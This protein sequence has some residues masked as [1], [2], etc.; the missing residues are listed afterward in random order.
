MHL[1]A[2]HGDAISV[3]YA[4]TAAL[5]GDVTRSGQRQLGGLLRDGVNSA[6]RYYL[7]HMRDAQTQTAIDALLDV[8][9]TPTLVHYRQSPE[10]QVYLWKFVDSVHKLCTAAQDEKTPSFIASWPLFDANDDV[11]VVLL[12]R[13]VL[14][15]AEEPSNDAIESI[16]LHALSR[17][18]VGVGRSHAQ[19]LYVRVTLNDGRWYQ[20]R[21]AGTRLFNNRPMALK[22]VDEQNEYTRAIAEQIVVTCSLAGVANLQIKEVP[23]LALPPTPSEHIAHAVA[24]VL[25]L[26][27]GA[28]QVEEVKEHSMTLSKSCTD[29]NRDVNVNVLTTVPSPATFIIEPVEEQSVVDEHSSSPSPAKQGN[30]NVLLKGHKYTINTAGEGNAKLSRIASK[31]KDLIGL[32]K[33]IASSSFSKLSKHIQS[34]AQKVQRD[35]TTPKLPQPPPAPTYQEKHL[36]KIRSSKS[37]IMLL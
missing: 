8:Q 2:D 7:C 21:S 4:G 25:F 34:T 20:W 22:S 31:G 9:A 33:G 10:D 14:I 26:T 35:L 12:T 15:V 16:D 13:E 29:L 11:V 37:Q 18:E 32:S 19:H 36:T 30:T 28:V 17:V 27:T 1:W 6:S 3:Q 23:T 24:G 5:K